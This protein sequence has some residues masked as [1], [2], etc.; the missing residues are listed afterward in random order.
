MCPKS[1]VFGLTREELA[2]LIEKVHDKNTQLEGYEIECSGYN[3]SFFNIQKIPG[4]IRNFLHFQLM[5]HLGLLFGF[6]P[7]GGPQKTDLKLEDSSRPR[8]AMMA[9]LT[10]DIE[11]H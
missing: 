1:T 11:K 3:V 2:T 4:K 5:R 9:T 8:M 6:A 7:L 10:R